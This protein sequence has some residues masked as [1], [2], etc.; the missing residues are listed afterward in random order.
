MAEVNSHDRALADV[1]QQCAVIASG[2]RDE[3]IVIMRRAIVV[4]R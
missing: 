3:L 2:M 1:L 4:A